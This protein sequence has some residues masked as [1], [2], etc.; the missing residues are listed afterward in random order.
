MQRSRV[1]A[2]DGSQVSV[3]ELL[4]NLGAAICSVGA[5]SAACVGVA[6]G[7]A[8]GESDSFDDAGQ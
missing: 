3:Y 1:R 2:S 8:G 6:V 7:N 4:L 5:N